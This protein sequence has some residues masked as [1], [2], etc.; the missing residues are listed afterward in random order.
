MNSTR[1]IIGLLLVFLAIAPIFSNETSE[2]NNVSTSFNFSN[3]SD[4]YH[5]YDYDEGPAA[6]M[7][8][9][10][11]GI[12]LG[13]IG[14][15]ALCTSIPAGVL[16]GLY[17]NGY[18]GYYTVETAMIGT[19]VA[20]NII[21]GLGLTGGVFLF[22]FSLMPIATMIVA[23]SCAAV[24]TGALVP[25]ILLTDRYLRLGDTSREVEAGLLWS[26]ATFSA[27][28]IPALSGAV[29][30]II[31]GALNFQNF[32]KEKEQPVSLLLGVDR[33]GVSISL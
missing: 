2:V 8:L 14:L 26:W 28:V 10:A 11:G 20:T 17:V 32:M 31:F 27:T 22:A 6:A 18:G 9:G 25:S 4:D 7:F 1:V 30:G 24:A 12:G 13:V 3:Y 33:I 16:T 29:M 15:F 23:L 19:T 21:L 5:N